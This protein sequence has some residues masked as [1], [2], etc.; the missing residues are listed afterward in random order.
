MVVLIGGLICCQSN[1]VADAVALGAARASRRVCRS[2]LRPYT[3]LRAGGAYSCV[4]R[5][6]VAT[7]PPVWV[8]SDAGTR[9]REDARF[10]RPMP[11]MPVAAVSGLRA[12]ASGP[13][14]DGSPRQ[15]AASCAV[16]IAF[17]G[18]TV[19]GQLM[20]APEVVASALSR[21]PW[22]SRRRYVDFCGSGH[23]LN[24]AWLDVDTRMTRR[25]V[26]GSRRSR[27]PRRKT[28]RRCSGAVSA[29]GIFV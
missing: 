5:S 11:G 20:A 8:H 19:T 26:I 12:Q 22:R 23:P 28:W 6:E 4:R 27:L 16:S 25:S 29:P 17:S 10:L 7:G 9:R 18:A 1:V 3:D 14:S 15:C 2:R 13:V 21:W 24:P